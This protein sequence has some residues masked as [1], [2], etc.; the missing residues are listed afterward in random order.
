MNLFFNNY[1]L[2]NTFVSKD[3]K[4]LWKLIIMYFTAAL[5]MIMWPLPME[6]GYKYMTIKEISI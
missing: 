2:I 1:F 3:K 4:N 5:K 6:M